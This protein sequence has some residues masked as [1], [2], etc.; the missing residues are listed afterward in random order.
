MSSSIAKGLIL[1]Q[2]CSTVWLV[3]VSGAMI[4]LGFGLGGPSLNGLI[5]R[6]APDHIQGAVLGASQSAQSLCRVFGPITAGAL[7]AGFGM[8]MPYYLSGVIL[9]VAGFAALR[10]TQPA[11]KS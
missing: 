3:L 9:A 7:F 8:D 11:G 6:N 4:V 2:W 1:L 10:L 5:S